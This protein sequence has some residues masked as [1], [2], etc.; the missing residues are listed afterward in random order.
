V[1]QPKKF[2]GNK[3]LDKSKNWV[4]MQIGEVSGL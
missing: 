1:E 3:D 4:G 2:Q